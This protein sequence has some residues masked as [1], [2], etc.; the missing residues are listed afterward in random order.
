MIKFKRTGVI[1]MGKGHIF[2]YRALILELK[3]KN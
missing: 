1:N 2:K 3:G